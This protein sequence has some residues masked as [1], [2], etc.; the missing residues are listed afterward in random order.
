[1]VCPVVRRGQP[2]AA[3]VGEGTPGPIVEASI[4]QKYYAQKE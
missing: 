2:E 4:P 3:S 1:L